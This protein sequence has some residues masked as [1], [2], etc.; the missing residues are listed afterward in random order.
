MSPQIVQK[1]AA[2]AQRDLL[3]VQEQTK[4][5][6][7][8]QVRDY[9]PTEIVD[10]IQVTDSACGLAS[11]KKLSDIGTQGTH[12]NN[13]HRDLMR[14]IKGYQ[15]CKPSIEKIPMA[16]APG[17]KTLA[18]KAQAFLWPHELFANLYEKYPDMFATSVYSGSGLQ[19]FWRDMKDHPAL[20]NH[21]MRGV[22]NWDSLFIPVSLHGD[23]VPVSGCG[24]PWAK[25]Y[26]IFSWSSLLGKGTTLATNFMIYSIF[27]SVFPKASKHAFWK[28]LLASFLALFEGV[29]PEDSPKAGEPLAGGYRA[30]LWMLKGDLKYW[31]EDLDLPNHGSDVPCA[32]CPANASTLPWW[33]LSQNAGWIDKLHSVE[34]FAAR[35]PN[36][37]PIFS[38][39]TLFALS[40][41]IMH[42]KHMGTDQYLL[43]SIM[44]LLIFEVLPGT[45]EQNMSQ[46]KEEVHDEYKKVASGTRYSD[47]RISMFKK[48]KRSLCASEEKLKR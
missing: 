48:K 34:D 14:L 5:F 27:A 7:M 40:V 19:R 29:W 41:D 6:I 15:L 18:H 42:V 47:L 33:D 45:P 26:T 23:A 25:S 38:L 32:L 10:S 17:K 44:Y 2:A 21:P 30:C 8:F 22:R 4:E 9:I 1:L 16:I 13:C 24:K 43:G 3:K 39:V 28:R 36:P 11:V 12:S 20:P 46:V 31:S 35:F 37:Y